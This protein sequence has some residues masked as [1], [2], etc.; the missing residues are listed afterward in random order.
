[1]EETMLVPRQQYSPKLTRSE[2]LSLRCQQFCNCRNIAIAL[3]DLWRDLESHPLA[4]QLQQFGDEVSLPALSGKILATIHCV[5]PKSCANFRTLVPLDR[6]SRIRLISM[7][8]NFRRAGLPTCFPVRRA[9]AIPAFTR[10]RNNSRSI[11]AT[12]PR[13]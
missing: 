9:C 3:I 6:N 2:I 1:M 4:R 11:S 8:W 7:G 10:S 13:I 5:V 12:A